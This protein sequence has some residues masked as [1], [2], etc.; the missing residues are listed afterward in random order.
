MISAWLDLY[1]IF[2][3]KPTSR[4]RDN[5]VIHVHLAGCMQYTIS[6]W[7]Q[8]ESDTVCNGCI[9]GETAGSDQANRTHSDC[10]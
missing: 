10:P 2:G 1:P 4:S 9:S 8:S 7:T 3:A 5:Y 6:V